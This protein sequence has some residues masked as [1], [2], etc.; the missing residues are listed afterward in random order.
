MM[1]NDLFKGRERQVRFRFV[2]S[3]YSREDVWG[4]TP[5]TYDSE[6]TYALV[7]YGSASLDPSIDGASSDPD[8]ETIR[9]FMRRS[10]LEDSDLFEWS[11]LRPGDQLMVWG[12]DGR[13]ALD[14]TIQS[15][16]VTQSIP[17]P[18]DVRIV[19]KREVDDGV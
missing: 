7:C 9:V 13:D 14:Y 10:D 1:R 5:Q 6:T 11:S 4:A 12:Y 16:D 2:S 3:G 17:G 18:Y 19:A 8:N 15:I